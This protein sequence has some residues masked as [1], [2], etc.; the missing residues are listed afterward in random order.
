[1]KPIV[2]FIVPVYNAKSYLRDC[3]DS[4]VSQT[5]REIEIICVDDRSTDGSLALV[6]EYAENDSRV[7]SVELPNKAR[8]G[9]ARNEGMKLARG[10]YVWF[11]D[12][13]DFI[14]ADAAEF[15]SGK[16]DA[17]IDVDV[18]SFCGDSFKAEGGKKIL[19]QEGKIIKYWPKNRKLRLPEGN[20][21]IPPL[22]KGPCWSYFYRKE[23]VDSFRFRENVI[24]EDADF[25]FDVLTSS[26]LFYEL[27]YTPYHRR[28]HSDSLTGEGAKGFNPESLLGRLEACKA[29]LGI[30]VAKDL[31]FDHFAVQWA[32]EWMRFAVRL[33]SDN[34]E[35]RSDKHDEIIRSL[36]KTEALFS[37][38]ELC[39]SPQLKA[40]L[41]PEIIVSFT[42]F[43]ERI[44]TVH[45]VAE[46]L[47]VQTFP[48]DR[49]ILYLAQEQFE[50]GTLPGQ[51]VS[52]EES[53]ARFEIRFC[54]DLKPHK[55]YF[56]V[57]REYPEAVV[58]TFDDDV[59]Y[60]N[61]L[62]EDLLD[63]FIRHPGAVSCNYGHTI[64]MNG[65]DSFAPYTNWQ[66][67]EKLIGMP[68]FLTVAAGVGGVLYPPGSIPEQAFD[69]AAIRAICLM[70]DDLW[71]K[72]NQLKNEIKCVV[73]SGENKFDYIGNTQDHSLW[74][75]NKLND[76]NG[77][78]WK[79]IIGNDDG[80]TKNG[81]PVIQMLYESSISDYSDENR[82]LIANGIQR[83]RPASEKIRDFFAWPLRKI[84]GVI[85]CCR[86]SGFKYTAKLA[87]SHLKNFF[88]R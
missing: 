47:L 9:G 64:I 39:D 7:T 25:T 44:A 66:A 17:L 68:S 54:D 77:F 32:R 26:C 5:L 38:R 42:S 35:I 1:M 61:T 8:P 58:I 34:P 67:A 36:Q 52:L 30:I 59:V 29:I 65:P 18:L 57:M 11:V 88:K 21:K 24:F 14:D 3:L 87:L 6:R 69:I 28:I 20:G 40:L 56:Y 45:L 60:R 10:K 22:I 80:L 49:I 50:N 70:Q 83:A 63:S 82:M 2:S 84:S 31:P 33:Y 78:V 76:R 37:A 4:L 13:D 43:P 86:N 46:S 51:L 27:K 75:S 19:T 53:H 48:C 81:T 23:Y 62:I 41:L 85:T 16:M 73:L 55:K 74:E 79:K 71:L 12:S 15:L 72:W